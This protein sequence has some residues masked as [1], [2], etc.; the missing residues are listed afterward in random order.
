[1][2]TK[3]RVLPEK[4]TFDYTNLRLRLAT[5]ADGKAVEALRLGAY[6]H[7]VSLSLTDQSIMRWTEFDARNLVFVIENEWGEPVASLK[8]YKIRNTEEFNAISTAVCPPNLKFPILY[9]STGCTHK[10]YQK[11]GLNTLLKLCFI[12][13]L[14]NSN[15]QQLVQT[16]NRGTK[17]IALLENLGFAFGPTTAIETSFTFHTELLLGTLERDDF[18]RALARAPMR[19]RSAFR[20][21]T[22]DPALKYQMQTYLAQ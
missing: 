15:I 17:R 20:Q 7:A 22:F 9:L 11:R 12:H 6:A 5:A 3:T 8:G 18:Q 16:I 2:L 13:Y 19:I 14:R 1:M 21:M 10:A 4:S